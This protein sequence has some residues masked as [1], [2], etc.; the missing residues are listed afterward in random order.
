MEFDAR[1]KILLASELDDLYGIPTLDDEQRRQYF[2][3]NSI[4]ADAA[5]RIRNISHR[6]FFV[7][8]LGYFKIKPICLNASFGD[9]ESEL[10]VI[11]GYR[12]ASLE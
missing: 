6:S 9:I 2:S 12:Q 5:A 1:R 11:S 4:G 7:A 10:N 8:L 3:L